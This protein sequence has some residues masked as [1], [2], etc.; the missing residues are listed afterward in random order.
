MKFISKNKI[1]EE[2]VNDFNKE[3]NFDICKGLENDRDIAAFNLWHL[4]NALYN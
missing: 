4:L 3:E 2:L 1:R